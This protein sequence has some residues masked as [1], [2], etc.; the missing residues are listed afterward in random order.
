MTLNY[1]EDT[2]A[3]LVAMQNEINA[4]IGKTALAKGYGQFSRDQYPYWRN[5]TG[6]TVITSTDDGSKIRTTTIYMVWTLGVLG[7][8][9][10]G[11]LEENADDWIVD[12]LDYFQARPELKS[13]TLATPIRWLYDQAYISNATGVIY[14]APASDGTT[15]D[16]KRTASITFTLIAPFRVVV[17]RS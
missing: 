5:V 8:G 1:L 2:K 3:H 17:Q 15:K 6:D 12:V 13:A 14:S 16:V 10:E 9:E 4:L 11:Q 7:A